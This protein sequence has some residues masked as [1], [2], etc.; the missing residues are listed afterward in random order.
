MSLANCAWKAYQIMANGWSNQ[1]KSG[2][3]INNLF[4]LSLIYF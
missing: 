2:E 1:F 3:L 4:D